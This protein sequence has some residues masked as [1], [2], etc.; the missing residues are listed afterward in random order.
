MKKYEN[1]IKNCPK[2]ERLRGKLLESY[3]ER[4]R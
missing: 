4:R 2:E 3:E 1:A